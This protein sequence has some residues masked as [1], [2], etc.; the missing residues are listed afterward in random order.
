MLKEA[1]GVLLEPI[2]GQ[3]E[4]LI[5]AMRVFVKAVRVLLDSIR[6]RAVEAMKMLVH[7]TTTCCESACKG[8]KIGR[9]Q[10][11]SFCLCLT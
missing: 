11:C 5:E 7:C 2:R 6:A 1:V 4:V 8:R 10:I 3:V 9:A